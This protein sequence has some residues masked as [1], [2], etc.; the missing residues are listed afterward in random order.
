[1]ADHTTYS[2]IQRLAEFV[3][4]TVFGDFNVISYNVTGSFAFAVTR[5]EIPQDD[6]LVR[7]QSP[8]L[9][10]ESFGVNS[11]DCGA[12]LTKALQIGSQES[13]FLLIYLSY[14]EGR[15]L[16]MGQKIKAIDTEANQHVDMVEAFHLLG[17]PLDL[18][19]YRAAAEIIKDLNEEHSIRLMTNNPKK[20]AGLEE[21]GV[22]ISARVPLL[23]DPPNAA[24]QR[25]LTTKKHK[26]GHILPNIE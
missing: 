16:G 22:Q 20:V 3:R 26:M 9:F 6:L 12:Q 10:G 1:M 11:C 2:S 7:V 25:Y 14:Q 4:P 15:G 21:Y 23:I 19:E 17:F 8:C 18:R 13:S 24:C 5:G